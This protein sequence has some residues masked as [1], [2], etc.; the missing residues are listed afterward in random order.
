[1]L[2]SVRASLAERE[3]TERE[4]LPRTG[5]SKYYLTSLVHTLY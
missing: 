4:K 5:V 3:K 2:A 1:M